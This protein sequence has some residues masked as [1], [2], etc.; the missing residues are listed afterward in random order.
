MSQR[1]RLQSMTASGE[2]V[3]QLNN[4]WRIA[5]RDQQVVSL[6]QKLAA[7]FRRLL[8]R[9]FGSQETFNS[10]LVQYVNALQEVERQRTEVLEDALNRLE[11]MIDASTR[12]QESF[13]ARERRME[14]ALAQVGLA[15]G[16][17]DAHLRQQGQEL[18]TS[19]GSLHH[20]V[21]RLLREGAER[22]VTVAAGAAAPAPVAAAAPEHS[23]GHRY[24]GFEDQFRGSEETTRDKQA[25]YLPVF[26]GASDVLDIGCGRG[27]FMALLKEHGISTRGVDLNSSMVDVC[28][29]NGLDAVQGDA[30]AYLRRLPEGSLGGLFAAQVVEHLEPAYLAQFIDEAFARLR[31]GAPIVLETINPACW[32]AFFDSYLRDITH[33]QPVHPD[34]LSFLLTA[35]GFQQVEVRYQAPYPERHK[36]RRVD[37]LP[38]LAAAALNANVDQLNGLMFGYFDYAVIARRP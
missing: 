25:S 14:T 19:L 2:I 8:V 17:L 34:T 29:D 9:M 24:V 7:P 37:G 13:L 31:P 10:L 30:L 33:V 23:L 4:S 26:E 32:L 18:R 35:A 21:N 36:L 22:P 3:Q 38:E 1:S 5:H 20:A 28:R 15:H 11:S 16:E 12:F 6:K 27:E